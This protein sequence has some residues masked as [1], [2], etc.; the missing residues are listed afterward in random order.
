MKGLLQAVKVVS[1]A[2][3]VPGPVAAARLAAM[4]AEVTKVEPPAGDPLKVEAPKWYEELAAGQKIVQ[5]DLKHPQDRQELDR[6]LNEASLLITSF[7]P[8]ALKRLN[9]AWEQL[10]AEHPRLGVVNIVGYPSPDEEVPGH[11]LTYQAKLGLLE[12]P[13]LPVT[14]HADMAGAER[15][16]TAALGLL[17]HFARTGEAGIATVSLYQA[18]ADFTGPL[19]AGLTSSRGKL[20]GGFPFYKLYQASDGW[21]AVAALEPAFISRLTSALE[22]TKVNSE[23]E[24]VLKEIFARKPARDWELWAATHDLP[25]VALQEMRRN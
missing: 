9:V 19:S 7:R 14:L 21:I 17:L 2:V 22:L 18:L 11:D 1:L 5:L 23:T 3:N 10:H 13:N 6:L 4:G 15:A 16:V 24:S 12:P 8:S 20:R 25:I